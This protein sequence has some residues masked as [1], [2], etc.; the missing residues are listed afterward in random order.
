METRQ[1]EE[2]GA[3]T[4]ALESNNTKDA[5]LT[6][7]GLAKV[8]SENK[9]RTMGQ[10]SEHDAKLIKAIDESIAPTALHSD[11]IKQSSSQIANYE[12]KIEVSAIPESMKIDATE[13]RVSMQ[14]STGDS[15]SQ[16]TKEAESSAV[17]NEKAESR[18]AVKEKAG[19][20]G[21][22][23]PE[24]VSRDEKPSSEGG[25]TAATKKKKKSIVNPNRAKMSFGEMITEV[26]LE[27]LSEKGLT[28]AILKDEMIARYHAGSAR[29]DQFLKMNVKKM[30]KE[31]K[32]VR[33]GAKYRL[34]K[35]YRAA[36]W[37]EKREK[38]DM[39]WQK[40][41]A[42]GKI[43]QAEF[44]ARKLKMEQEEE[45]RQEAYDAFQE[46][47]DAK[48]RKEEEARQRE[49]EVRRFERAAKKKRTGGL[50]TPITDFIIHQELFADL[51]AVV[52][53]SV[54]F[55]EVL[56]VTPFTAEM[57]FRGLQSTEV[58]PLVR[59]IHL[60][61]L[62]LVL[63]PEMEQDE[64][65]VRW[66][67]FKMLNSLTW[68][69]VLR[70]YLI[71]TTAV[72]GISEIPGEE[73]QFPHSEL[74]KS[75]DHLRTQ[76]YVTLTLKQK[77]FVLRTLADEVMCHPEI[78]EEI[79]NLVK[80]HQEE[81][82]KNNQADK[83]LGRELQ[84]CKKKK[85]LVEQGKRPTA[86]A[87]DT[88]AKKKGKKMK[89]DAKGDNEKE[90]VED[91]QEDGKDDDETDATPAR[92]LSGRGK[93]HMKESLKKQIE[94]MKEKREEIRMQMVLDEYNFR[95]RSEPWGEDYFGNQYWTFR[96]D[97]GRLWLFGPGFAEESD[98]ANDSESDKKPKKV[99]PVVKGWGYL[100]T[101]K[102]LKQLVT[103]LDHNYVS[104]EGRLRRRIEDF[105]DVILADMAQDEAEKGEWAQ[106]YGGKDSTNEQKMYN[107]DD[108]E[109]E[110]AEVSDD[111]DEDENGKKLKGKKK[112]GVT[113]DDRDPLAFKK[114][115]NRE[116][117]VNGRELDLDNPDPDDEFLDD[118]DLKLFKDAEKPSMAAKI[119]TKDLC[120]VARFVVTHGGKIAG[121]LNCYTSSV[122]NTMVE[123]EGIG[124]KKP[125]V[126]FSKQGCKS[127]ESL[128]ASLEAA[129]T[130]AVLETKKD[131]VIKGEQLRVLEER[132]RELEEQ[133]KAKRS[134]ERK[135]QRELKEER[136]HQAAKDRKRKIREWTGRP[137]RRKA[138]KRAVRDAKRAT[139]GMRK[140]KRTHER[141]KRARLEGDDDLPEA[142]MGGRIV[143]RVNYNVDA[144]FDDDAEAGDAEDDDDAF[145]ELSSSDSEDDIKKVQY[146]EEDSDEDDEVIRAEDVMS[147]EEEEDSED[148]EEDDNDDSAAAKEEEEESEEEEE[149]KEDQNEKQK[150]EEGESKGEVE[151]EKEKEGT[152]IVQEIKEA[153]KEV[154]QD[155]T[156]IQIKED[157]EVSGPEAK[158][159][160]LMQE[161]ENLF[162][163]GLRIRCAKS[164]VGRPEMAYGKVKAFLP[165]SYLDVNQVY[166]RWVVEFE[167]GSTKELLE[168]DMRQVYR[169]TRRYERELAMEGKE[170]E[171]EDDDEDDVPKIP[172]EA[173]EDEEE[174]R[175]VKVLWGTKSERDAWLYTLS[176]SVTCSSWATTI[177]QLANRVFV[178]NTFKEN[179]SLETDVKEIEKELK[180]NADALG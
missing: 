95:L 129:A 82:R 73:E 23:S 142:T 52:E 111:D 69:E 79:E 143:K 20:N 108:D 70:R 31:N 175:R 90:E 123:M 60:V 11:G 121:G 100:D 15:N 140:S 114:F 17:G 101:V 99:R 26:L 165:A 85:T 32:I 4:I 5:M 136:R 57:L 34:E 38:E 144:M 40:R 7:D 104:R 42:S 127:L 84:A 66:D 22:V 14:G 33:G 138:A 131:N 53:F 65:M 107:D 177:Y 155:Q 74:L 98:L 158:R 91:V 172:L 173:M 21:T 170:E 24:P 59:E 105:E 135:K 157:M 81:S 148:A 128:L 179:E 36:L 126:S 10:N 178:N 48:K 93:A 119:L 156:E 83:M 29:F 63:E 18:A 8:E 54:E 1:D 76:P 80:E 168:D 19:T 154:A 147:D 118:F 37:K 150:E 67:W 164:Y 75:A 28:L 89:K 122:A 58:C 27:D 139:Q 50:P 96:A 86:T 2:I 9:E 176:T 47:N 151:N 130:E 137:P 43:T 103:S 106:K 6:A 120:A 30:S 152:K 97:P 110:E 87:E 45:K 102:Q 153:V 25:D 39:I 88:S 94:S 109:E 13:N 44:D 133:V 167:D 125:R 166:D 160:K 149:N 124:T 41:L 163:I 134:L 78:A 180:A 55:A 146:H 132:R 62:G 169:N 77:I 174:R 141:V 16:T 61:L 159:I 116:N 12:A 68:Q 56:K 112:L 51:M 35:G 3:S 49:K 171:L 71:R 117:H 72:L 92:P 145:D 115:R 64:R 162:P 113:W 46:Q 161:I